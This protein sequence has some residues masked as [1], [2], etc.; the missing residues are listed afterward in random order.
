[1]T[2]TPTSDVALSNLL[3]ENR[4]FD[5]PAELAASANLKAD[6]YDAASADRLAFWEQQAR[7]LT[8]ATPWEKTLEWE[9]PFAKWFVGG[10]LNAA[11]NC[12]DR[13]VEAG[14][15]DKV[16]YYWEG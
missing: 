10:T 15:G 11:Y 2:D 14:R 7:R 1:M 4:H 8:W 5:P 9:L 6:A 16:A 12:V 3:R 13:H